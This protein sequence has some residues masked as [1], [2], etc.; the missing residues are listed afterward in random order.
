MTKE[1]TFKKEHA[2]E[3]LSIAKGDIESAEILAKGATTR[4]ENIFFHVEQSIEKSL[5]ALL[6]WR[7]IPVPLVHEL[8]LI[9]DRIPKDLEVPSASSLIDLTQFATV[10][11]YE[12]GI[13]DFTNEEIFQSIKLAHE[14]I[15]WV[16]KQL[17]R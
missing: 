16:E 6:V 1:R 9:L 15:S 2:K 5:K 4:T 12:E 8:T 11:R 13:A 17:R 10:R 14:I 7:Q 3:L